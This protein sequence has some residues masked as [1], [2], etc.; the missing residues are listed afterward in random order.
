MCERQFKWFYGATETRP[1]DAADPDVYHCPY[2]G[3]TAPPDH[4]WTREQLDYIQLDAAGAI[5]EAIGRELKK[6]FRGVKGLKF[7]TRPS[8]LA[9]GAP[10]ISE[11]ADLVIVEPPCHPWEPL[12][13][14]EDWEDP[15]HCLVCGNTFYAM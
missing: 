11:P 15:L 5:S 14:A 3:E 13:V 9:A 6:A 8:G 4:W 7:Q 10:A 12:K 2:C 1:E